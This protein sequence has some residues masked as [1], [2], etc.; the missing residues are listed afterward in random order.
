MLL[1]LNRVLKWGG[2]VVLTTPN[3]A[4]AFS[5]KEAMAGSSPYIYGSYNLKSRADRHSRE[6]TPSDVRLI[7][8]A[9]GFKVIKL[10]SEDLWHET[11]ERFLEWLDHTGVPRSLRGDNIFAVGRK[12]SE[13][14][15]RFPELIYD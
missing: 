9:S 11:D 5:I 2:L 1:E 13:Q 4:S 12:L 8:E 14:F 15:D 6:Y 7:L 3:I 10:F